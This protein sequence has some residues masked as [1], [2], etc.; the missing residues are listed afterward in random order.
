MRQ[1]APGNMENGLRQTSKKWTNVGLVVGVFGGLLAGGLVLNA[2]MSGAY[3][4]GDRFFD[5][6]VRVRGLMRANFLLILMA[7]FVGGVIGTIFG[8]LAGSFVDSCVDWWRD[9]R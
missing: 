5:Y 9:G 8:G 1:E 2:W 6:S 7:L 4:V 3:I